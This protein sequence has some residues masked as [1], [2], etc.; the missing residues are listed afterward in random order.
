MHFE[1]P[2]HSYGQAVDVILADEMGLERLRPIE[3]EAKFKE[4]V[5]LVGL[6]KLT[7]AKDMLNE[8]RALIG[9]DAD[10][11]YYESVIQRMEALGK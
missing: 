6:K 2:T 3:V 4:V 8:L 10:I 5:R 9:N 7:E 11:T 1:K